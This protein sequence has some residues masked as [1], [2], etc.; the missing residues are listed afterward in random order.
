M[1]QTSYAY[2]DARSEPSLDRAPTKIPLVDRPLSQSPRWQPEPGPLLVVGAHPRDEI[3]GAGGLIHTWVG[4][5]NDVT[6]LSVTD[7]EADDL[8]VER[9]DLL[10][11]DE[12]RSALRKLCATHV[13]V[14]RMGLRDGHVHEAQNRLR[15][16]IDAL[17]Q[18]HMTVVGPVEYGGH[19][20]HEAV[21]KVCR[22]AAQAQ[23][24]RMV[25]YLPLARHAPFNSRGAMRWG[26][27][28]LDVEARRAKAYALQCF[29]S[30][31][32]PNSTADTTLMSFETFA[33]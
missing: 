29:N 30:Q 4:C 13:S 5:G 17:L 3:F 25:Q 28:P 1:Q 26:R 21:G 16:A 15:H 24:L 14:V 11:R 2:S 27:F 10:R 8:Q 19:P 23:K 7:G 31:R 18:P 20:D 9:L 33:I 12:L 22:E 6:V 32:L